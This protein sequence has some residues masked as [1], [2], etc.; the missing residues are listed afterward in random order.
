MAVCS[1]EVEEEACLVECA[2]LLLDSGQ[3][4]VNQVQR[5]RMT[6]IMLAA[7]YG[8][9]RLV[10]LLVARGA[11]LNKVDSQVRYILQVRCNTLRYMSLLWA[12]TSV[13][14]Y[15]PGCP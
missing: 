13:R 11:G 6:A 2:E 14:L 10:R 8:R 9:V 5:Q 4:D 7:K 3:E 12:G 15:R 1:S